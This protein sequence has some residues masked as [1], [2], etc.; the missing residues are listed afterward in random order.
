MDSTQTIHFDPL[1]NFGV[2]LDSGLCSDCT[3]VLQQNQEDTAKVEIPAHRIILAN[4][5]AFFHSAFTSGMKEDLEHRVIIDTDKKE[6]HSAVIR[7]MY[8]GDLD[9]IAEN[10]VDVLHIARAF[11]MPQLEKDVIDALQ[12]TVTKDQ[13][14]LMIEQC[15]NEEL[16]AELELIVPLIAEHL[17]EFPI[18]D[19]S[20]SLDVITFSKV[21]QL[22]MNITLV[23]KLRMIK[24]FLGDWELSEEESAALRELFTKVE[25]SS[26]NKAFE[27][28]GEVPVWAPK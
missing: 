18:T 4:S 7:W 13:L 25:R 5:S 22:S 10:A 20:N 9:V 8:T 27:T 6:L 19:L 28:L 21:L 2:F 11:D 12:K 24:D 3:I 1:Y 26:L 23:E 16:S 14:L 15:F 17:Q